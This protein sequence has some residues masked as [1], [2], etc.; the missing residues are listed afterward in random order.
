MRLNIIL[1]ENETFNNFTFAE[2]IHSACKNSIEE[3]KAETVA[4]MILLQIESEKGCDA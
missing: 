2:A 3:V 4:K 1:E